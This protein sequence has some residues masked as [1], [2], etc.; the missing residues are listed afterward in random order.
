MDDTRFSSRFVGRQQELDAV[1]SALG[2]ARVVS[3]TG[4]PGVGKT[5]LALELVQDV[6]ESVWVVDLAPVP[7]PALL[8]DTV[9]AALGVRDAEPR[10]ARDRL[11]AH[12]RDR[13]GLVV[14]D[15]CEHLADAV[16]A[17]A[18]D[19]VADAPGIRVLATS[20]AALG[21]P[22]ERPVPIGTLP[23]PVN[24]ASQESW[25]ALLGSDAARLFVDR[26]TGGAG[27]LPDHLGD[28]RSVAALVRRLDG[29]PLALELAAV[30]VGALPVPVILDGLGEGPGEGQ[31]TL[32]A[33]LDWAHDLLD[34]P[35]QVLW[36]RATVFRGS[37]DAADLAA[38]AGDEAVPAGAVAELADTLVRRALL[39]RVPGPGARYR[40]LESLR[41]YGAARLER[42]GETEE[43]ERRHRRHYGA[44]VDQAAR[45]MYGARG[46]A[47]FHALSA[48]HDNLRVALER[49]AEEP[50]RA[51]EGLRIL[52]A[53]QHFWVMSG[54]FGEGRRWLDRLDA[55]AAPAS[56]RAAGWETAGRLA[57]LQGDVE[58]GQPLLQQALAEATACGDVTWRA[59]ALHGLALVSVFWG[60]AADAI[61]L[62]QEALTLHRGGAD[63]FGV[64][65]ALVQLATVHAT[66]GDAERAL[67]YAEE[68]IATSEASGERWCAGLA[69]WTQALVV[70]RRGDG[71]AARRYAREV[72]TLKQPFGDRLGMAMSLELIAWA[73]AVE[74]HSERAAV[75]MGAT[76]AGLRSIGGTLFHHLL[77][78]HFRAVDRIR[79]DLGDAAFRAA[80]ARGAALGFDAAV[81]LAQQP[82]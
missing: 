27:V 22:G 45:E 59:H 9:L 63:P 57:I 20:R 15:G 52:G 21:A 35:A 26:A 11:L 41:E 80:Q 7:S 38:V 51:G 25:P 23:L 70:W 4:P 71:P 44:L 79:H 81:D 29:L 14:L 48:E 65:L 78:D 19:L 75:L 53:L 39:L 34:P 67:A 32:E 68:C 8:A 17:L 60:D 42:A 3:V 47:W 55:D 43:L 12:L 69:R 28:R 73:E 82:V 36:R 64:P 18:T 58:G 76:E 10:S 50:R 2:D 5:R 61:P 56:A 66:L 24:G 46:V 37:F 31:V 16:G 74:R 33:L 40:L 1:R 54:R 49:C 30:Q 72:L 13:R 6:E 77:D 62:L